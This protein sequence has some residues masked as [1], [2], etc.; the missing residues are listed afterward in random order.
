MKKLLLLLTI[1]AMVGTSSI[2]Q[3]QK[4][5]KQDRAEW[6][7]KIKDELKLTDDQTQKYTAI[8]KEYGDKMDAVMNDASLSKE[9]Q[10][11][12][13]MAIKKEKEAKVMEFLTPDQQTKYREIMASKKKGMVKK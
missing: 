5:M 9:I 1:T 10:K 13:K 12:R 6:E 8:N 7:K 11:E 3:E 2:A 4:D